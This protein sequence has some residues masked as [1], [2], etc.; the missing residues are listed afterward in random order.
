MT[1]NSKEDFFQEFGLRTPWTKRKRVAIWKSRG[2][3]RT[4]EGV[5]GVGVSQIVRYIKITC[6]ILSWLFLQF[7]LLPLLGFVGATRNLFLGSFTRQTGRCAL[8]PPI[9]ASLL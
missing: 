5:E 7:P 1:L 9:P 3:T 6:I 4:G 2:S 8:P